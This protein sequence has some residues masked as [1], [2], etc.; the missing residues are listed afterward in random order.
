MKSSN[1]SL[2]GN[3]TSISFQLEKNCRIENIWCSKFST[4]YF[5]VFMYLRVKRD[6]VE[7]LGQYRRLLRKKYEL[8]RWRERRAGG[9]QRSPFLKKTVFFQ[10]VK[11]ACDLWNS[12]KMVQFQFLHLFEP[13]H[14]SQIKKLIPPLPRGQKVA[15]RQC[16]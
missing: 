13:P 11:M 16:N 9:F 5:K 2:P 4:V 7:L 10:L 6:S 8:P 1:P 14:P 15:D 12:T 3:I